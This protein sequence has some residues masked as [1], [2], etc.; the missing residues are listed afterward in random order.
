MPP[1]RAAPRAAP[2]QDARDRR[3]PRAAPWRGFDSTPATAL[4]GLA[5][6][7][8]A[9]TRAARAPL[10]H[11]SAWYLDATDRFLAGAVLY[12]DIIEVNPPLSFYLTVPPVWLARSLELFSVPV[13]L[14]YVFL[15]S[16]LSLGL[17]AAVLLGGKVTPRSLRNALLLCGLLMLTVLPAR[18]FGERDHLL[19]VFTWPYLLVVGLRATGGAVTPPLAIVCG[20]FAALGFGL[21][22]H[23]LLLAIAVELPLMVQTARRRRW[24][25]LC[26]GRLRPETLALA[27]CLTLYLSFL[28]LIERTYVEFMLPFALA[29][30]EQAHAAPP[31]LVAWQGKA[32]VFTLVLLAAAGYLLPRAADWDGLIQ[33]LLCA[34]AAL[35]AVFLIQGKGWSYQLYPAVALCCATATTYCVAALSATRIRTPSPE[36]PHAAASRPGPCL[37]HVTMLAVVLVLV[38]DTLLHRGRFDY[39]VFEEAAPLLQAHAAGESVYVFSSNVSATYPLVTYGEARSASRYPT[40][41]LLPGL[42]HRLRGASTAPSD[43]ARATLDEIDRYVSDSVVEDLSRDPPTLVLVD[44]REPKPYFGKADFD[45][46]AHFS[47]DPRFAALWR[48]YRPLAEITGYRIYLRDRRPTDSGAGAS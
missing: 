2:R 5:I 48:N 9:I 30:Y 11:D 23:F 36:A 10:N 6:L 45:Y 17:A 8:A 33:V 1:E 34:G 15:L 21:K 41:W 47:R 7:A 3:G 18:D 27:A 4:C 39:R 46:I 25:A 32:V 14:A 12:K 19:I 29:V 28:L 31:W 37:S 16:A 22:P 24:P 38:G 43:S 13:F 26:F 42:I 20:G 44:I 35:F 40:H